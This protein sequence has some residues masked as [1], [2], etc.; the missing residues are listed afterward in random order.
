MVLSAVA[1]LLERGANGGVLDVLNRVEDIL[2]TL[3]Q[4]GENEL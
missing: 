1:A 3:A 2:V 4:D